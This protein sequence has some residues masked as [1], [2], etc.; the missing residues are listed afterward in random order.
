VDSCVSRTV[1]PV[2]EARA[3]CSEELIARIAA[4]DRL[5]FALFYDLHAPRVLGL[6]MRCLRHRADA[7]DVL[8]DTF[9]QLWRS[10]P[11]YA[12]HLS[13]PEVWLTLIARS[14]LVDFLRRRRPTVTGL[15]VQSAAPHVDP[16]L[17]L[18]QDEA[19]EHIH[20]ALAK[21]PVEQR[22]AISLA[23]FEG[24]T[25]RQVAQ[26]QDIPLGTAKTRIL[27]GIRALRRMLSSHEGNG[28]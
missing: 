23:F 5:S 19:A 9:H 12:P 11:K 21:L 6:L 10:A 13:S 25:H 26:R 8:Q 17:G 1:E 28:T 18:A 2:P 15:A 7:E 14:R 4:G 16:L 3:I 24:L 22:S 27:L 20:T